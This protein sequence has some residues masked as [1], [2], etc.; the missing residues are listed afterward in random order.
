MKFG[1]MTEYNKRTF[2]FKNYAENETGKLVQGHLFF[3]K[4]LCELKVSGLQLD[5][6]VF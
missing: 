6:N 5:F 3:K 1:Q 2:F 4:V